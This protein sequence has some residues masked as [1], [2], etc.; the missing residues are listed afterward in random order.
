MPPKDEEARVLQLGPGVPVLGQIS[1]ACTSPR[2]VRLTR[3]AWAG[4]SIHF[5]YELCD[6]KAAHHEPG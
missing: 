1:T 2:P 4:N 5:V 3:N 6:L